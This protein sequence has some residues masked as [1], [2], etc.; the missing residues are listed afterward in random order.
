MRDIERVLFT[1]EQVETRIAEL[2]EQIT[3]DYRTKDL[4]LVGIL[5]GAVMFFS[6]LAKNIKLNAGFEFMAVS[7]Y[8]YSSKS[9]GVVRTLKDLDRPI[10]GKDVIIIEDIVDT[11]LTLQYLMETLKVREPSTMR[12]CSLLQKPDANLAGIKVD[13][14]GFE[15]PDDYVIGYGLDYA[16]R[17]RNMPFVAVLK[18]EVYL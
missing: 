6:E 12:I 15:V 2:G 8:G 10:K 7:S 3:E 18:P 17:Y 5:N 9:S 13:Y 4:V 14:L 11:G 1:Q 16:Q